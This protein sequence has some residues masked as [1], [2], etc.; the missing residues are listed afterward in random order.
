MLLLDLVYLLALLVLSPWL[1]WRGVVTGRYRRELAAK[2]LGRVSVPNPHRKPVAWFHAV[3]VGEVNL[4]GTLVPAFRKRHP[5]WLVVVSSTTDTGIAEARKKFPELDVIPWPFDFT[6]AVATG[7][8][9][10]N[11]SLVVL[12]ESELWPN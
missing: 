2:L 10:V 11:P 6:W 1:A 8:D 9:A 7:L 4:L 5:D 3:S 12:T